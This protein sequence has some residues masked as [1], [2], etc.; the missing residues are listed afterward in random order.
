MMEQIYWDKLRVLV[1]NK[2]N[3]RCP[4]CHN[5]GQEK[6]DSTDMMS[7]SDFYRF[8]DIIKEQPLSELNFSGGEPFMN[9][10]ITDM[11]LYATDN[12]SCDISCATN[13][14]MLT[15]EHLS[16]LAGTRLKF[17]IQFPYISDELFHKSTGNGKLPLILSKIKRVREA[18]LSIGL[19]T[20]IQSDDAQIYRDMILFAINEELP[21]KLLPQIGLPGSS[22]YKEFIYPILKEYV[23]EFKDKKSGATRWALEKDGHKTSVL[24]IDSPC[25][26]KDFEQC[27]NFA[28]LRVLPD[29]SLQSCILKD[30]DVKL[31]LDAG[32]DYVLKQLQESWT[33]FKNC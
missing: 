23:T 1:T 20:V 15:E 32:K 16:K 22:K 10:E 19:N 27:R 31:N 17:N 5:E 25:F 8:A 33:S 30:S 6:G 9:K 18:G 7:A 12:L 3:Y 28:E 26:N 11:I 2:C 21:L 24:Y 4:F 29:F 14:S 13:L